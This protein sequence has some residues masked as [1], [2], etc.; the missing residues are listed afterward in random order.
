M[1]DKFLKRFLYLSSSLKL[2]GIGVTIHSHRTDMEYKKLIKADPNK[3]KALEKK[4]AAS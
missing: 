1:C 2:E 3:S 4:E